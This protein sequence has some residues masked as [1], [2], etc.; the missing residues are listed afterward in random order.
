[1]P[2]KLKAVKPTK[3][4]EELAEQYTK[5]E[6][7]EIAEGEEVKINKSNKEATIAQALLDAGVEFEDEE[8]TE[9]N[10]EDPTKEDGDEK[11]DKEEEESEEEEDEEE[12]D[13]DEEEDEEDKVETIAAKGKFTYKKAGSTAKVYWPNGELCRIYDKKSV[14]NPAVTAKLFCD[15]KNN[16]L[17]EA[18]REGSKGKPIYP[19]GMARETKSQI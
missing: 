12:D 8:D 4:A 16:Q 19:K 15:K 14:K 7:I 3:E 6:L 11:A 17:G 2:T 1:M 10:P 5:A 9:E 13:E 18:P